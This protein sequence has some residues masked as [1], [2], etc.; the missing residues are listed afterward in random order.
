MHAERLSSAWSR[1]PANKVTASGTDARYICNQL[2]IN[3][4]AGF[5]HANAL[6]DQSRHESLNILRQHGQ[7]EELFA[8]SST[9]KLLIPMSGKPTKAK[10]LDQRV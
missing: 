10:G 4:A 6:S 1:V 7:E 9:E 3:A 2:A 5:H 8:N